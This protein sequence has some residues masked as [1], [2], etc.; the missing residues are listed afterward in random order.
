M[1]WYFILVTLHKLAKKG[2]LSPKFF[3]FSLFNWCSSNN[4]SR[5]GDR[6]NMPLVSQDR[7]QIF[8]IL[9][10]WICS[11]WNMKKELFNYQVERDDLGWMQQAFILSV[12]VSAF[13][14][15]LQNWFYQNMIVPVFCISEGFY[16][17]KKITNIVYQTFK[18]FRRWYRDFVT[19]L[20]P[21]LDEGFFDL[22]WCPSHEYQHQ[23]SPKWCIQ[24]L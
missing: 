6:Q 16:C 14:R 4:I 7:R 3:L 10:V 2:K 19:F 20:Y 1:F 12:G 24:K 11:V 23:K 17:Q 5:F 13:Q 18:L 21:H 22:L 9:L 8:H 15:S